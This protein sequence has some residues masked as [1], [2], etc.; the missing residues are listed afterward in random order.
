MLSAFYTNKKT[1]PVFSQQAAFIADS[2]FLQQITANLP[3]LTRRPPP[4]KANGV[5]A[6]NLPH[7]C[8]LDHI[9]IIL[10]IRDQKIFAVF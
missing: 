6:V 4:A 5:Y 7:I 2:V 1:Q 10:S 3:G 9:Y 8:L